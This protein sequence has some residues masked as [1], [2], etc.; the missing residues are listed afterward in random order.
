MFDWIGDLVGG[1]ADFVSDGIGSIFSGGGA[2]GGLARTPVQ[3][4]PWL[5]GGDQSGLFGL[6][7]ETLGWGG[8]NSP[9]VGN[10]LGAV[11]QELL[12]DDPYD[13]ALARE[14]AYH[15]ARKEAMDFGFTPLDAPAAA[16]P[17]GLAPSY[18]R[19]GGTTPPS[20]QWW[21]GETEAERKRREA[22]TYAN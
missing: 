12:R 9:I 22:L 20:A 11:G 8:W 5:T 3:G 16:A 21:Q 6:A 1:V 14:R 10:I 18:N 13:V 19:E 15:D 2:A 17:T 4:L 7:G